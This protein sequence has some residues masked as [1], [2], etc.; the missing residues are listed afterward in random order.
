MVLELYALQEHPQNTFK[1]AQW[2]FM[3]AFPDLQASEGT[4]VRPG[5]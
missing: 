2:A 3:G 4:Q 5:Q 1:K